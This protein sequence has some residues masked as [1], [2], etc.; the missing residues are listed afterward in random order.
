MRLEK[1]GQMADKE[2]E[3]RRDD[4]SRRGNSGRTDF[5]TR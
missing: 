2:E 5:A 4:T 1:N 3:Y